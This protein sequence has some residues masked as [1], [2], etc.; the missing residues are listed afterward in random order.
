M[1]DKPRYKVLTGMNYPP[2]NTRAG[3]GS[4]VDDIPKTSIPWLLSDGHIV[5]TTEPLNRI[6][7]VDLVA[8][9][10]LEAAKVATSPAPD[11]PAAPAAAEG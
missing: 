11:A 7:D 1:A 5:E 10:V 6:V 2:N 9:Q 8:G 4:V 3:T